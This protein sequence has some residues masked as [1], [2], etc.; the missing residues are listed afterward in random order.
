MGGDLALRSIGLAG[1]RR[2][3]PSVRAVLLLSL[4][5]IGA[6]VLTA[7][8]LLVDLRQKELAH[9]KRE[10]V[11]LT[12]I[13]SEQTTRTFEGVALMMRGVRERI[14]DER[15]LGLELDSQLI[16]LLLQ[17]RS[18]GLPQVKSVFVTD[19]Q[20]FGVNSSR[21]DFIERLSMSDREFF[22][23]FSAGGGDEIFISRPEKARVDGRW[24]YYV[25][26]RLLDPA[27]KFRG[28]LAAAISIE[29]FESL[30]DSI[31]LDFIRRIQLLNGEG[32]LLAGQPH[33]EEMAGRPIAD[34]SL[35]ARLQGIPEGD[36]LET[37]ENLGEGRRFVAYRRIANYPLVVS[38]AI[39][40]EDALT[41]WR[42]VMRPLVAG[43]GLVL[44]FVL[45][46]TWMVVKNLLRKSALE[47]ALKERDEQ[48]RHTVQSVQDAIVTVDS[49]QRIILL[50]DAAERM[51]NLPA[52]HSIGQ[53]IIKLLSRSLH[54]VQA[55]IFQ[56]FLEEGGQSPPGQPPRALIEVIGEK[57]E[58]PVELSLS[59]STFHGE[60]LLT[61]VFRDLSESRRIELDLLET[62]RQLQDLSASLQNVREEARARIARELHDELGQLLTGIR[63]EVSWLGGRLLPE[64]RLLLDKVVS[65]K[66]QIDQTI[67]SV[68]RISSELRPLVLDDLG[69][70]AAAGWYVDQFSA[71]TGLPVELLL[72]EQ[73]PERGDAV[74]TALFR[75][76]Q[77]SLTNVA[78]H[79]R[80]TKVEVRLKF[81][82]DV[83]AL[84]IRDDGVGFV[85]DPGKL[86]DMGLVGMRERAQ[87]LGG[88][89]TITTAPGKGTLIEVLI[90]AQARQ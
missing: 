43:L 78:R 24:T 29:Y 38:A 4:V 8:V 61:L 20:G 13:L 67:A 6:T 18:A 31:G 16:Q 17:A 46:T 64:Q 33:D 2:Q 52:G 88:N 76:L 70:A 12:R 49:A 21:A 14:S 53:E 36:A 84:S 10:I 30:Y 63:M 48:L 56:R 69:F 55:V 32:V 90:P 45:A 39:D 85:H 74:A 28:V 44:L 62:N 47:S 26:M 58:F 83:W 57:G 37:S 34:A 15:G 80:A 68:R 89:F 51:F 72:T 9:A 22:R 3:I 40:E 54:G 19:R 86:D 1:L 7:T 71:R 35:L 77:E 50:N 75:V 25:S 73:D 65:V 82:I 60:T 42:N 59:A 79:A 23:Y 11:S 87:I 5:M 81:L 66:G 27:G 41:P